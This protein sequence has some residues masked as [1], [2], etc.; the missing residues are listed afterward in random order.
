[1]AKYS[2]RQALA[3]AVSGSGQTRLYFDGGLGT[4]LQNRGLPSGVSPEVFCLERPEVLQ[5]IHEAYARA[6]SDVVTTGTFGGTSF[7]LPKGMDPVEFNRTMAQIARKAADASGRRVFVAGSV[8]P[9]GKF[10]QPLGEVSFSELV[11]SFETQIRGLAQG[12]ADLIV[13]ET[14]IDIAE[15]RAAVIAA[16]N[17]CD[18]PIGVTM[19]FEDGVTLTGSSPEVCVATLA[20]L[21][22]DFLGTNCSAGPEQM[23]GTVE[24]I[25]AASPVPVLVQPNAGLPE[26]IDGETVFR[27][28][29]EPFAAITAE[30]AEAGAILLGG[31]CGTTPA[32]IAALRS[33]TENLPQALPRGAS[34]SS[35]GGVISLTSRSRLVQIGLG[36][37]F[38]LIGER[39]NPTG[40]KQLSQELV[41]GE[42]KMALRYATEQIEAGAAVLDVNVGAPMVNEVERLPQLASLLSSRYELP[43][44]LDSSNPEAIRAALEFCPAS[45]LVNSISGEPGRMELLGPVCRDFGA[46][47][48][49]L[50]LQGSRLP[51]LASERIAIVEA[52]LEEMEKLGI[53][54]RLAMVDILVLSVSSKP[55]AAS[56]CFKFIR[57]CA[58]VLKLPTTAGLSNISFGLPARELV[59]ASF[60]SMGAACGLNAAIVN[61]GSVRIQEAVA[62]ARLLLGHDKDAASFIDKYSGW[63]SGAPGNASGAAPAGSGTAGGTLT[64]ASGA[65]SSVAGAAAANVKSALE[66]AVIKGLREDILPLVEDALKEGVPPFEIVNSR[67]IPGITEVGAMYERKEYFLPQL[68][69]SAETMQTAFGRLKPLLEESGEAGVKPKIIMATVE[70]DIHDIGK[71]IVNLMLGN[72]GFEVIDLGKDVS[73]DKIVQAAEESGAC[74]I[75]LS[76]LMTT[77]MVRMRDTIELLK[78]R[79]LPQIKVMIGGAVVTENFARSIGA[80]GYST[81]AVGAVRLARELL[82]GSC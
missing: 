14:Q 50:P 4:M 27:L 5:S 2:F 23:R 36:Q 33:R 9:T 76:A 58:D 19:T 3:E 54:R 71:N 47:F 64:P 31:C 65:A 82:S 12:G 40:K 48:I 74:L 56:E 32:H 29:P 78:D 68:L 52:L 55:E 21:G 57:Y 49:L 6:G 34:D 13:I 67:L 53:P 25:L 22:V 69:R 79:N 43:L 1:M 77:T 16:R 51:V 63:T 8:G 11:A 62:A 7:K 66:E 45:P 30:F 61:P 41:D 44:S 20:N 46:P 70:G 80:H 26:L 35:H 72:H 28:P 59:N 42:T 24:R 10:L 37:E 39:I 75:G 81:D 60:L 17:V 38:T 15:S 73:A 18:L